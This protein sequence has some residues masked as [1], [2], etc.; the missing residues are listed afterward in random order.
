MTYET[1]NTE[2]FVEI[3][4]GNIYYELRKPEGSRFLPP[5]EPEMKKRSSSS[6]TSKL[7]STLLPKHSNS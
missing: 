7:R 1:L 6:L 2:T 4:Y 3:K 5:K